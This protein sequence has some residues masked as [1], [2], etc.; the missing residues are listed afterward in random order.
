MK[1]TTKSIPDFDHDTLNRAIEGH[2]QLL[3]FRFRIRESPPGIEDRLL[4]AGDRAVAAMGGNAIEGNWRLWMLLRQPAWAITTRQPADPTDARESAYSYWCRWMPRLKEKLAKE[5][6]VANV[7]IDA[8]LLDRGDLK[9]AAQNNLEIFAETISRLLNSAASAG[10]DELV[11][12]STKYPSHRRATI[13]TS[14]RNGT[15]IKTMVEAAFGPDLFSFDDSAAK[16]RNKISLSSIRDLKSIGVTSLR[17]QITGAL[18]AET[19][20][21]RYRKKYA[22]PFAVTSAL[23]TEFDSFLSK[24]FDMVPRTKAHI[25]AGGALFE[26]AMQ[27]IKAWPV[28]HTV[29]AFEGE[30]CSIVF[31][32]TV[33]SPEGFQWLYSHGALNLMRIE[34][35]LSGFLSG[36]LARSV[37]PGHLSLRLPVTPPLHPDVFLRSAAPARVMLDVSCD[38]RVCTFDA[39]HTVRYYSMPSPSD[40]QNWISSSISGERVGPSE[41][42]GQVLCNIVKR[43]DQRL[44]KQASIEIRALFCREGAY[45][46]AL[47]NCQDFKHSVNIARVQNSDT[48]GKPG[49]PKG[50]GK[51][52]ELDPVIVDLFENLRA[53][54]GHAALPGGRAK[55]DLFRLVVADPPADQVINFLLC[56]LGAE[57]DQQAEP[58]SQGIE[59]FAGS[60]ADIERSRRLSPS[61]EATV[62]KIGRTCDLFIVR[63]GRVVEKRKVGFLR[64]LLMATFD[65]CF[66]VA[67]CG[68]KIA[69][70]CRYPYAP[71]IEDAL[72]AFRRE[73]EKHGKGPVSVMKQLPGLRKPPSHVDLK[74]QPI[75]ILAGPSG[76]GKGTLRRV[77]L[78]KHSD[79]FGRPIERTTR[80]PR[81]CDPSIPPWNLPIGHTIAKQL[82]VYRSKSGDLY[83]TD[84]AH[85]EYLLSRG[86]IP[87]LDLDVK[88]ALQAL[89]DFPGAVLVWLDVANPLTSDPEAGLKKLESRIKNRGAMRTGEL[90][91]RLNLVRQERE[92]FRRKHHDKK[93]RIMVVVNKGCI[94]D[95]RMKV[96][97]WLNGRG[98]LAAEGRK[99]VDETAYG[100]NR[101]FEQFL[102]FTDEKALLAKGIAR[103]WLERSCAGNAPVICSLL[104]KIRWDADDLTSKL[105]QI[106]TGG[107]MVETTTHYLDVGSGAGTVAL[108]LGMLFDKTTL[109]EPGVFMNRV[110]HEKTA[111]L[112]RQIPEKHIEVHAFRWPE[113]I[114]DEFRG[115][116]DLI[117][118]IHVYYFRDEGMWKHAMQKAKELLKPNGIVVV[119]YIDA[120]SDYMLVTNAVRCIT[121]PDSARVKNV[122]PILPFETICNTAR[123]VFREV[124]ENKLESLVR[125]RN[126]PSDSAALSWL[127]KCH[128]DEFSEFKSSILDAMPARCWSETN[129]VLQFTVTCGHRMLVCRK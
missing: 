25:P 52:R 105:K 35:H 48:F 84:K 6:G 100:V 54:L 58:T 116:Y 86:M 5:P 73:L 1:A 121:Q 42:L 123:K 34:S 26:A 119:V 63:Y 93:E 15:K 99:R 44:S 114:P 61:G 113:E 2:M 21:G 43:L 81:D 3:I 17:R 30:T 8:L 92:L 70:C 53:H 4:S 68:E 40:H 23:A 109:V 32:V 55:H 57:S 38:E 50:N 9:D 59:C 129:S 94:D 120:G 96:F 72:L 125:F 56:A 11:C 69:V 88:G 49:I 85:F 20:K 78:D 22:L 115:S 91:S 10:D 89:E 64:K 13:M 37:P 76:A 128:Y 102:R 7:A 108:P 75:L 24:C 118:F 77:L 47:G 126:T 33:H 67:A 71:I 82:F 127:F 29:C 74:R 31:P 107:R 97:T 65:I 19:F 117:T 87:I 124:R 14:G 46:E 80:P 36:L 98:V 103:A 62:Q 39:S 16:E 12:Y 51:V 27:S 106:R 45:L 18:E 83:H 95:A 90:K 41:I 110:L 104:D 112:R 28:S 111:R 79:V 101:V 122:N 66:D 60:P